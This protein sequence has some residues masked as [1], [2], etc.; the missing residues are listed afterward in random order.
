MYSILNISDLDRSPDEPAN[1]DCPRDGRKAL[2]EPGSTYRSP[3]NERALYNIHDFSQ[4]RQRLSAFLDFTKRLYAGV[5]L[6][7]PID[8]NRGHQLFKLNS[9]RIVLAA[10]D[11][12]CNNDCFGLSG[13]IRSGALTCCTLGPPRRGVCI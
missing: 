5:L 12:T 4:Y 1:N 11:S 3:R 8:C 13:A 9:R 7:R 2:L 6:L 10:F